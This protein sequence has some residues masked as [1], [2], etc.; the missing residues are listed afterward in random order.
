MSNSP[1]PAPPAT[2]WWH[3]ALRADER[4]DRP[5]PA[6]VCRAERAAGRAAGDPAPAADWRD[7][8]AAIFAGFLDEARAEWVAGPGFA[9]DV[10]EAQVA[11][12]GRRLAELAARV[13]VAELG[14]AR[15]AG[16]VTGDSPQA[17]FRG[18]VADRCRPGE[19]AALFADYPVLAR[20]LA[21]TTEQTIRARQELFARFAAD[22]EALVDAVLDGTDPGPV[23]AVDAVGDT[24]DD[25][26][27][28]ATLTFADGRKVV[29]KP[30]PI[31]AHTHFNALLS[32]VSERTGLDLTGVPLVARAAYGWS[33]FIRQQACTTTTQVRAFY[34]R[35]GALLAVLHALDATDMHCENVVAAGDQ[36]VIVDV[37]TLLHPRLA[38]LSVLGED[39]AAEALNASVQRTALLPMIL[40]GESGIHDVSGLGGD[41]GA[42]IPVAAP[43][44]VDGGR[45]T[46]RLRRA[47]VA[48]TAAQNRPELAG[49]VIDPGAHE[50]SLLAGFRLAYDTLRAGAA[51]LLAPEGP[52]AAF[53]TD[54]TRCV[55][56]PTRAYAALLQEAT[57][58]TVLRAAAARDALFET[59]AGSSAHPLHDVLVAHEIGALWRGDVPLVT[60]RPSS[61]VLW[62]CD[63]T[64]VVDALA[65]APLDVV[66]AKVRGFGD[67]DR[68]RQEWIIRASLATREIPA[69]T[70]AAT[71]DLAP[72][73]ATTEGIVCAAT[74]IADAIVAQSVSDGTRANWLGLELVD[75][76]FWGL[77][78]MSA[79]LS[80]GY[81]GTALF[82]A[83]TARLT[84]ARRYLEVAAEAVRPLPR[85]L[86]LLEETPELADTVGLGYHGLGGIAFGIH[87]LQQLGL[88]A[89]LRTALP[90]AIRLI[91]AQ[92][93]RPR[94][95]TVAAHSYAE[96]GAGAL[97]ALRCLAGAG[98]RGLDDVIAAQ[99][100]L[101]RQILHENLP[102]VAESA[103]FTGPSGFAHGLAG[104]VWAIDPA[105]AGTDPETERARRLLGACLA[106]SPGPGWCTGRAGIDLAM[107][108][109]EPGGVRDVL[110]RAAARPV[111]RD[112]SLC[113][114][115]LGALE[116]LVRLARWDERAAALLATRTALVLAA[117]GRLG[118]LDATPRRITSPGLLTGQAGVGLG[119]LRLGFADQIPSPLTFQ[120]PAHIPT[121]TTPA[122]SETH[123][124]QGDPK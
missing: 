36:P 47:V 50:P 120:D 77:Q 73:A 70:M 95:R 80:T 102:G 38:W 33:G 53:A 41:A 52:L 76:R 20:L 111:L 82:L 49:R 13:L 37:E 60:S 3:P 29:Y 105:A 89:E 79:S 108:G 24:H 17:R 115:E 68:E 28:V 114:G 45:D 48:A 39:P 86:C 113:H 97:A 51:Q 90:A 116:P 123:S 121:A 63:G 72:A 16:T 62:T 61:R 109:R 122:S 101:I 85:L 103:E 96:G 99:T 30:R 93:S 110:D 118:P 54:T 66:A 43:T 94:E 12:L 31:D 21:Q 91:R 87:R 46:M 40:M 14:A 64:R 10:L 42:P 44:W 65:A 55:L 27:C 98:H 100:S 67:R 56:R 71:V 58:P 112:L 8:F 92:A 23:I 69:H 104:L 4:G 11:G 57:H 75:D 119:L 2:A 83:E 9:A 74:G 106:E 35:Q 6:W 19:L 25:G 18:F 117:I 88:T 78:P 124:A 59:L 32:W 5:Q 15:T 7:Q 84:G 34:R 26:R 81:L 1:V 107:T 22:R